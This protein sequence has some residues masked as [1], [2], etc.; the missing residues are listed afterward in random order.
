MIL[1]SD[2]LD[3]HVRIGGYTK[4]WE[5]RI[6]FRKSQIDLIPYPYMPGSVWADF[7][8]PS[9][10]YGGC[11]GYTWY[12]HISGRKGNK[13]TW[14]KTNCYN[15]EM[16]ILFFFFVFRVYYSTVS[17]HFYFMKDKHIK[18]FFQCYCWSLFETSNS[19]SKQY[20]KCVTN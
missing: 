5:I 1:R 6:C 17:I 20:K 9:S 15:W 19:I 18:Y 7:Y 2:V 4:R 14:P 13:V 3:I 11:V 8:F 10:D 16:D 12:F